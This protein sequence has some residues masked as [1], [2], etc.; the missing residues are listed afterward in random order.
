MQ[1]KMSDINGIE[2]GNYTMN[3]ALEIV[4]EAVKRS[5]N[6]NKFIKLASRYISCRYPYDFYRIDST[7]DIGKQVKLK[8]E[9]H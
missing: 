2:N 8:L 7:Q 6:Y 5:K 3:D 9:K 4:E 1:K